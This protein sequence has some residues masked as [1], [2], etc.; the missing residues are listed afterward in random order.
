MVTST[1]QIFSSA[2][3]VQQLIISERLNQIYTVAHPWKEEI[4]SFPMMYHTRNLSLE[5]NFKG[6]A[7]I[8]ARHVSEKVRSESI[9]YLRSVLI[10]QRYSGP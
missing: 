6:R 9:L 2:S 10:N 1:A 8:V 4:L 7:T 3:C 5:S